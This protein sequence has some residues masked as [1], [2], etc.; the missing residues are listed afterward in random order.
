MWFLAVGELGVEDSGVK[1]ASGSTPHTQKVKKDT[2]AAAEDP[3]TKSPFK[4]LHRAVMTLVPESW[5][6]WQL[7][8]PPTGFF[9]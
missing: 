9:V 4:S 3:T 7:T 5:S 2:R 6:T 8:R 1:V